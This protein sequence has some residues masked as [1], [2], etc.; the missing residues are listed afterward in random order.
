MPKKKTREEFIEDAIKVH[1]NKFDYSKVEYVN[2]NTKVCIICKKCG[3]EWWQL[4]N[5]H[6]QGKGCPKCRYITIGNKLRIYDKNMCMK[7][8]QQCKRKIDLIRLNFQVYTIMLKND[9][10]KECIHFKDERLKIFG[11]CESIYCYK[12]LNIDDLN[13]VYV[14]LTINPK[15]R[16]KE[17]RNEKKRSSVLNFSKIH[18][19]E[20]PQMEILETKL[21]KEE[22]QIKEKEYCDKFTQDGYILINIAKTGINT[23]SLGSINRKWTYQ[24]CY[25]EAQK[26]VYMFDFKKYCASAYNKSLKMGWLKDFNWLNYK[27]IRWTDEKVEEVAKKYTTLKE[28]SENEKTAY[29]YAMKHKL[30]QKFTWLKRKHKLNVTILQIDKKT[31]KIINE[32]PSLT[33]ASI[34]TNIDKKLICRCCKGQRFSTKGYIFKYKEED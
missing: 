30:I 27:T 7:I 18:N 29:A 13:Y 24:K 14:G 32:Y 15:E 26:Y 17:H 31:N 19:I 12:F 28:F 1:G 2:N 23:S 22:A 6:L 20:I 5:N 25:K 4:P 11:K 34:Q 16:D 9:W 3:N 8:A 33:D 21:T 10:L